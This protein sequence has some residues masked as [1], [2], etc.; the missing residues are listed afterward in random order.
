[1]AHAAPISPFVASLHTYQE[2]PG[3]TTFRSKQS[4]RDRTDRS[5]QVIVFKRYQADTLQGLYL[6]LVG[7]PGLVA[8]DEQK[9][10]KIS[11]GS[12][13][14][15]QASPELD[16][17]TPSLPENAGQYNVAETMTAL[18]G[19]IPLQIDIPLEGGSVAQLVVPPFAVKEWRE[20]VAQVPGTE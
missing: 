13:L 8:L 6:R 5:W 18:A 10:L 3:Q 14:E 7:F 17:Q 20:L 11:T 12:S 16:P 15:W 1:M 9:P 4:L 19:D 2:L